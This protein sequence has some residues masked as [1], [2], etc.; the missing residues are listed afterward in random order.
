[1]RLRSMVMSFA[2]LL[3]AAGVVALFGLEQAQGASNLA[4]FTWSN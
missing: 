2:V 3:V 1:M 4:G